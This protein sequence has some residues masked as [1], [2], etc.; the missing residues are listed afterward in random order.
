MTTIIAVKR[1]GRICI[2]SDSLTVF[3]QRKELPPYVDQPC[4]LMKISDVFMGISGHTSWDLVIEK[5][6]QEYPP[7]LK[8][9]SDIEAWSR[10]FYSNLESHFYAN[11]FDTILIVGQIGIF[12][13]DYRRNVRE[14][15]DFAAIGSGEAY[16]LGVIEALY[17][18]TS[19]S[20]DEIVLKSLE[21]SAKFDLKTEAPFKIINVGDYFK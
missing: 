11:T 6:C 15:S 5:Y 16:A 4:K 1:A 13:I 10:K 17:E 18:D 7:V 19:L 2:G 8:T 20:L 9:F 12:E 21:I 14:F 3:G